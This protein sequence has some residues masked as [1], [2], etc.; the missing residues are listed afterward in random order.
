MDSPLQG[1]DVWACDGMSAEV[2]E[3]PMM[4]ETISL[5]AAAVVVVV[6]TAAA[7]VVVVV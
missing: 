3:S 6:P 1:L 2:C 5:A 7:V 4:K